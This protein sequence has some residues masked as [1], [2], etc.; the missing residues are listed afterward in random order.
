MSDKQQ[1][2]QRGES[3][4]PAVMMPTPTTLSDLPANYPA[5]L[6]SLRKLVGNERLRIVQRANQQMILLYWQI[7]QEI[8]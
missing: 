5:L 8:L 4:N 3:S 2:K 6:D 7:G 1:R